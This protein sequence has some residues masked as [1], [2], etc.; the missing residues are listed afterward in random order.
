VSRLSFFAALRRQ[1]RQDAHAFPGDAAPPALPAAAGMEPQPGAVPEPVPPERIC[2][3]QG[4]ISHLARP[5]TGPPR[6]LCRAGNLKTGT[7]AHMPRAD[8][9]SLCGD[10]VKL[11]G[12][13][14]EH[15]EALP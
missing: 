12:P 11:S 10:C 6:P 8:A 13:G 4:R 1:R 3:P 2:T 5:G 9:L 7:Y 14:D 15:R